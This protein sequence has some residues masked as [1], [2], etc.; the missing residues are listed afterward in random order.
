[1][2]PPCK[3]SGPF[4]AGAALGQFLER[5]HFKSVAAVDGKEVGSSCGEFTKH[6]YHEEIETEEQKEEFEKWKVKHL[7]RE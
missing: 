6:Y 2:V 1:M 4:W 3:N 5:S 7:V